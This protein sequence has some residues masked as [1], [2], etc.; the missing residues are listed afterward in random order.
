MTFSVVTDAMT[1]NVRAE[2]VTPPEEGT[3]LGRWSEER[4]IKEE[5]WWPEECTDQAEQQANHERLSEEEQDKWREKKH[6]HRSGWTWG[7]DKWQ[8]GWQTID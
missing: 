8:G 1:S 3:K 7:Q 6:D 2:N 4:W 5:E